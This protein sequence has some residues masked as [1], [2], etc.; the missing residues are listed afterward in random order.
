[1]K[2][3]FLIT[4]NE[5]LG[6]LKVEKGYSEKT[7]EA[8]RNDLN[9][10]FSYTNKKITSINSIDKETMSDYISTC[11]DK[12]YSL[13]TISRKIASIR[14]LFKYLYLEEQLKTNIAKN[15]RI[16]GRE[17][18]LPETISIE[19]IN[20]IFDY[21]NKQNH[22]TAKRDI[23][24]IEILY[25]CGIRISELV[26]LNTSDIDNTESIIRCIGKG[27]KERL[28]PINHS[29]LDSINNYI[30]IERSNINEK[31]NQA[32]FLNNRGLRISR[33]TIWQIVK[34]IF[35][36][37]KMNYK[38]TPHTFRH[39]FATHILQ[40]GAS[41]RH[42]QEMLGHSSIATTQIY[43][44]IDKTWMKKEYN[45]AHPRA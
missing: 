13:S 45:K 4:T 31:Q 2:N 11:K 41:I 27:Q 9:Q 21:L 1:M 42:V 23:A 28:I 10:F 26:N 20:I 33:Q 18:K 34:I 25:G 17:N 40:G 29:A 15:I 39:T 12:E 24:I 5:F 30:N 19:E 44:H 7:I 43:T 22:P 8:Y 37:N 16:K 36:K 38:Y 14:S 35:Q 32:L 3:N 6:Y